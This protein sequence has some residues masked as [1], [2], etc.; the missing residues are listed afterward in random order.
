MPASL[1]I[2][3]EIA[4]A[5]ELNSPIKAIAFS[6][7]RP[8]R[9]LAEVAPGSHCPACAVESSSDLYATVHAA[10]LGVALLQ[11][12]LRALADVKRVVSSRPLKRQARVDRDV[13]AGGRSAAASVAVVVVVP[14]GAHAKREGTEETDENHPPYSQNS[15]LKL[16]H[17]NA[18][19]TSSI[20]EQ[21]GF[22]SSLARSGRCSL[23][24][25]VHVRQ[26]DPDGGRGEGEERGEEEG[27]ERLD[28]ERP[29]DDP[30]HEAR[31]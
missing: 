5:P 3:I 28:P 2:G 15:L 24:D 8:C 10:R 20:G 23:E 31:W 27:V 11:R 14:A 17:F 22:F 25:L 7:W 21:R 13:L 29:R 12:E 4:E 19:H 6:S 18:A 9:A 30:D 16:D 1:V 26:R